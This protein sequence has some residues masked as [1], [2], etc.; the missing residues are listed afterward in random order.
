M[1]FDIVDFYPS[2]TEKLLRK[3]LN[4]AKQFTSI[5]STEHDTI[6]HVRRSLLY[7]HKGTTWVK[8]ESRN[9]F[10]VTMGAY[11]GAEICELVGLFLLQEIT[12]KL[13]IASIGLYRDDGLAAM[14]NHSGCEAERAKKELF[15]IFKQHGLNITAQT[16]LK[17]T[18]FLDVTLDLTTGTHKPYR[19][20]NDKPTYIDRSSNHPPSI[21]K[22]IQPAIQRRVSA[23]S[24][25]RDIFNDAAP[26]YNQALKSSGYE[27]PIEYAQNND[28]AAAPRKRGN[29]PRRTIWFNPPYSTKTLELMLGPNF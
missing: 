15:K 24:S 6:M 3:C 9:Q 27:K 13:N 11:D 28:Q 10:D 22:N 4:W 2:I 8:K 20:P 19:K 18:D 7:D 16:N 29:R 23:L 25:N 17:S 14:E 12:T 26:S 5:S 21:I 1:T